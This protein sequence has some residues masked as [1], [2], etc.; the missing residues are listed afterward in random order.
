MVRQISF[1]KENLSSVRFA[2][3]EGSS[4]QICQRFVENYFP[5]PSPVLLSN[6]VI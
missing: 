5:D 3:V 6:Q 4:K 2:R 1:V